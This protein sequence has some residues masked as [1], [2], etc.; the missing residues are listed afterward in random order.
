MA[1]LDECCKEGYAR[2]KSKCKE[3]AGIF[4]LTRGVPLLDP[5]T[6]SWTSPT[7]H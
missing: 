6:A 7:K 4:I 5:A 3:R 1:L 2:R